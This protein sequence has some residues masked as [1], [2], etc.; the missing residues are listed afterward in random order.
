MAAACLGLL[1]V[2]AAGASAAIKI[3]RIVFYPG[4]AAGSNQHLNKEIS[5]ITSTGN[6]RVSLRN[7]TIRD[8]SGHIFR[9]EAVGIGGHREIT[10]HTGSGRDTFNQKY[11]GQDQYVWNNDGD[12]AT[13]KRASG[14]TADTCSYSGAGSSVNC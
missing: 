7:G 5:V 9:F 8:T 2:G 12:R 10:I 4:G 3:Q 13:L 1:L 6:R 14:S 11:W